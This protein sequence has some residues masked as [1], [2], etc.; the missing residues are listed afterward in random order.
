MPYEP[1]VY[2]TFEPSDRFYKN[3]KRLYE[4]LGEIDDLVNAEEFIRTMPVPLGKK[5]EIWRRDAH[6]TLLKTKRKSK[7]SSNKH[8]KKVRKKCNLFAGLVTF[9]RHFK[10]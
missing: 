8:L 1:V 4:K 2:K 10:S 7:G 9:K 5:V 6:L 3:Y